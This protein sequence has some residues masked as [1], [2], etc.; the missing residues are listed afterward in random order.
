MENGEKYTLITGGTEGI[1]FEL[2]K[3]IGRAH[4]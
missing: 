2:A 3:Q 1:G 4:V